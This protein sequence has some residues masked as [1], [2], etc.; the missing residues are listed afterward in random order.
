MGSHQLQR[1]IANGGSATKGPS[2]AQS[3]KQ[4]EES[5]KRLEKQANVPRR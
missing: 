3:V 2:L 5:A 1:D 4:A